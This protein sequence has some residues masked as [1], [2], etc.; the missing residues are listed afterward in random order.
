MRKHA[1]LS[2][3]NPDCVRSCRKLGF[4]VFTTEPVRGL[5]S[6]EQHHADMQ[7][8]IAETDTVFVLQECKSLQKYLKLHFKNVITTEKKLKKA[9]PQNVLLNI[10]WLKNMAV[11]N[12]IAIDNAVKKY[13]SAH[14]T[15]LYHTKQGYAKCSCVILN[16]TALITADPSIFQTAVQNKLDVLKIKTGHIRLNGADYGFIGGCC[17]NIDENLL[18]FCGEIQKHPDFDNIR[19]FCKNYHTELESLCSGEL[20]DIGGIITF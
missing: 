8:L 1:V 2:P 18:G 6:Y 9:Y 15:A 3:Q 12:T 20:E 10:A 11:C 17:G 16:Q 4:D 7:M 14:H 19:A 13:C 5:I